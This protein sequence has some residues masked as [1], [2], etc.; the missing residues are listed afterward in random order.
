VTSAPD[1]TYHSAVGA[2]GFPSGVDGREYLSVH[3]LVPLRA[4]FDG[5]DGGPF[6]IYEFGGEWPLFLDFTL[7]EGVLAGPCHGCGSPVDHRRGIGRGEDG[8][9]AIQ[10]AIMPPKLSD[11]G[12]PGSTGEALRA[13]WDLAPICET[14]QTAAT[15][16]MFREFVEC[17][18]IAERR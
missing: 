12:A 11:P 2:P 7:L 3:A 10:F 16:R 13:G 1:P 9:L 15:T 6:D 5:G 14:C 18:S 4:V 8:R 17:W